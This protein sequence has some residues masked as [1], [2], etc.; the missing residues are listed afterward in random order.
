MSLLPIMSWTGAFSLGYVLLAA[1]VRGGLGV[2]AGSA[3][4]VAF[5]FLGFSLNIM[6]S[7]S[8]PGADDKGDDDSASVSSS[9]SSSSL[10][11]SCS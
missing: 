8:V 1:W 6:L 5:S 3:P 4:T 11:V 7:A 2:T 9:A 10:G